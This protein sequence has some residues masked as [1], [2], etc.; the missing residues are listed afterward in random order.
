MSMGGSIENE[1]IKQ[2]KGLA[3]FLYGTIGEKK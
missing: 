2:L 3:D 1:C